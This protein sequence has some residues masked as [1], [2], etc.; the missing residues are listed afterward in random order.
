MFC[1]GI[2]SKL[3]I[4]LH[5]YV[6][7]IKELS[8]DLRSAWLELNEK[9][10]ERSKKLEQSLK[11]QQ[12]FFEAN[13]VESWLNEKADILASTDYGRD[14]DAATKLLTKHKVK[15]SLQVDLKNC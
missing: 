11:A 14:R 8:D 15:Y 5:V 1:G 10:A 12:F 3:E 4:L 6:T 2:K 9:A 7:Q 13:E